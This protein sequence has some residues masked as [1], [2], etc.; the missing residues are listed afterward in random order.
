MTKVPAFIPR[1]SRIPFLLVVY[2]VREH[3]HIYVNDN[4]MIEVYGKKIYI[5]NPHTLQANIARS[6]TLR[7][8]SSLGL[9]SRMKI[10]IYR[11]TRTKKIPI[12]TKKIQL[13]KKSRLLK[14]KSH[15]LSLKALILSDY[16]TKTQ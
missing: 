16:R 4:L 12:R 14:M 15:L 6:L 7:G 3:T 10:M 11:N 2:K 1:T 8:N 5:K 13:Q 9:E